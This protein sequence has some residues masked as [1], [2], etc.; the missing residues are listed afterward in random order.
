MSAP[1]TAPNFAA[2][3][4]PSY[5]ETAKFNQPA[6]YPYPY[7]APGNGAGPAMKE[8]QIP[9]YPQHPGA[10]PGPAPVTVQAV[11][12]QSPVLF[13]DRP[14][15]MCCPSCNKTIVTR[16]S[17]NAGALAWLSCGGLFLLGCWLGC[18]LIPFC[19]DSL[20]DADHYCP[21]CNALL[22]TYKRL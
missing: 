19:V 22:G 3:P 5:E 7:P 14:V 6:P 20:Q 17:F 4:P 12:V 18:C 9:P 8:G 10:M 21:N 13:H 2:A 11:Y 1:P 15:Q 16:V